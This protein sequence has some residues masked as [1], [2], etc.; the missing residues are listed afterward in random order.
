MI[1]TIHCTTAEFHTERFWAERIDPAARE[2]GI[3]PP[4]ALHIDPG[5]EHTRLLKAA[6]GTVLLAVRLDRPACP[7]CG[8]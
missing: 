5:D 3:D 2:L 8:R 1:P 4:N 6:D 7:T